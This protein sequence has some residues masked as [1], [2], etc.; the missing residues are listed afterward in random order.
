MVPTWIRA[1]SAG[2]RLG[3]VG[4]NQDGMVPDLHFGGVSKMFEAKFRSTTTEYSE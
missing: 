1:P 3:G 2:L 4:M